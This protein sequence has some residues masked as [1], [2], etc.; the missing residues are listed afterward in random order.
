MLTDSFLADSADGKVA[1]VF[2]RGAAKAR[3]A[4]TRPNRLQD[5][6]GSDR[7]DDPI[8]FDLFSKRAVYVVCPPSARSRLLRCHRRRR[9]CLN[10]V[11]GERPKHT[12]AAKDPIGLMPRSLLICF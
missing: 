6:I 5:P 12:P 9:E 11:R 8:V 3:S 10:V 1:G 4:R 2:T 7:S